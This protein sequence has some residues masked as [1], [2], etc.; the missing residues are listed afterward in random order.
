[1]SA[2]VKTS[3]LAKSA[4]VSLLLCYKTIMPADPTGL[5]PHAE[6]SDS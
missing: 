5:A 4:A 3:L 2:D 6:H 1:M